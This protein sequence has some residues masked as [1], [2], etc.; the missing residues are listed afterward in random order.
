MKPGDLIRL[1]SSLRKSGVYAGR[2]GLIVGMD[3]WRNYVVNVGGEVKRFH[4]TQICEVIN[5]SR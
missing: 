4:T 3:Q 2:L 5:K 1:D